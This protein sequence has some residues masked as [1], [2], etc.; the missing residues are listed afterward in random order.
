M[1]YFA[2]IEGN[3]RGPYSLDELAGAGVTPDTFVWCKEMSDW[4]RA[5]EVAEICR[6]FRQRLAGDFAAKVPEVEDKDKRT[7]DETFESWPEPGFHDADTS[8]P[9]RNLLLYAI[10]VAVACCP[11]TGV[12]AIIFSVRTN[13]LWQQGRREDAY[14]AYRK[15]RLWTGITFFLGFLLAA[16][17]IRW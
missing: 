1:K 4:R 13:K 16:L 8:Q 15:A 2:M 5:D 6:Y 10:A 12:L 9:P 7:A 14:E 17:F 3:Q 11:L